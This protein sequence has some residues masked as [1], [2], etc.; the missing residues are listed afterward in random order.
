MNNI[1]MG[2]SL[3]LNLILTT[4][5]VNL[6]YNIPFDMDTIRHQYLKDVK[7]YYQ[8]ACVTGTE[9]PPEYRLPTTSW[10][11]NS[12]TSWCS[13]QREAMEQNFMTD[14]FKLGKPKK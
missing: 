6:M 9:Y 3:G 7:F 8:T 4:L 13:K 1:L 2:L 5:V 14:V 10:N 12:P 11:D